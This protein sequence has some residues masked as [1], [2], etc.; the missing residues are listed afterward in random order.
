M[1]GVIETVR[2]RIY[3]RQSE[4]IFGSDTDED[5]LLT[6][7]KDQAEAAL[8]PGETPFSGE[9]TDLFKKTDVPEGGESVPESP[10]TETGKADA[11]RSG[12]SAPEPRET[13]KTDAPQDGNSA[14]EKSPS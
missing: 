2:Q 6:G 4:K 7:E 5:A 13:G 8:L 14:S 9:D 1:G 12:E 10:E 11:P 3:D